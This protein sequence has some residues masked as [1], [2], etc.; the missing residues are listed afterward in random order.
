M[1]E[2]VVVAVNRI[3]RGGTVVGLALD[4]LLVPFLQDVILNKNSEKIN[5][6]FFIALI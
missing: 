1:D 6:D 2:D 5:K 4:V 3:S